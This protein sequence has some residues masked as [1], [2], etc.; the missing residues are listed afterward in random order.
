MWCVSPWVLPWLVTPREYPNDRFLFGDERL[1]GRETAWV[2]DR[3]AVF[4]HQE[5]AN[6]QA[7]ER[8]Y[9]LFK[10]MREDVAVD[11]PNARDRGV[12]PLFPE[13]PEWGIIAAWAWAYQ[14]LID[15]LVAQP[16]VH[17]EQIVATGHS[18]GGK[19]ALCA[20]VYDERNAITAPNSSGSGGQS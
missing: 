13:Y 1:T 20:G 9:V 14:F 17:A 18:R 2:A 11:A 7:V 10:F 19:A 6:Q 3:P 8:G 4:E 15:T 16:F 12:F 5:F